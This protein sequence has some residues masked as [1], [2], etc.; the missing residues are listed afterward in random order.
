MISMIL[1]ADIG[2]LT[3]LYILISVFSPFFLKIGVTLE[4]FHGSGN[5][6]EEIEL[7]IMNVMGAAI[8]STDAFSI[9]GLTKSNPLED[10]GLR[11]LIA[12]LT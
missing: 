11:H 6:P 4:H 1:D 5:S 10:F 2:L 12:F 7:L 9:F 3:G 8:T